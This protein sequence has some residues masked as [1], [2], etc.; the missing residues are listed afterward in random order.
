MSFSDRKMRP[1][2]NS[3]ESQIPHV[4][5]EKEFAV[6]VGGGL[7]NMLDIVTLD[8]R[9][10]SKLDRVEVAVYNVMDMPL[11]ANFD[12]INFAATLYERGKHLDWETIVK[13][14]D[15]NERVWVLA[16]MDRRR[17]VLEAIT[18]FVLNEDELVLISADGKLDQLLRFA[19]K[20][21][22]DRRSSMHEHG[23]RS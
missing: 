13:V 4:R 15:D 18:V 19:M 7:F 16:G 10:I 3:I 20:P 14:R 17:Q 23:L 11:D 5:L 21:A 22:D 2:A 6:S 1:I 12:E 8:S 9:D